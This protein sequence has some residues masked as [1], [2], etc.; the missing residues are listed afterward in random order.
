A[1]STLLLP[2]T[3]WGDNYIAV[4]P[5][6]KDVVVSYAQPTL[7]IAAYQAGTTVTISPTAAIVGG[8]G[9]AGTGKGVPKTYNLN[10]GDVLQF[11]QDAQLTGSPIQSNKPVGVWGSASCLNIDVSSVYCDGAHQQI[12]PV[13]ALGHEYVAVRYRNRN[14]SNPE[15]IVPWRLVGAVDGTT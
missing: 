4:A 1:S 10:A 2:T 12:P 15:E 11:T 9:V 7:A 5:F 13:S 8:T 14:L 6:E 3:A